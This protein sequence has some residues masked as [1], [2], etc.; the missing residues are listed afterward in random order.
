MM[1][2]LISCFVFAIFLTVTF[3][4]TEAWAYSYGDNITIS[5]DNKRS[6]FAWYSDK[7]DQE[8]EPGMR[9]GQSW[10]LEGFFLDG[11]SLS[12]IGGYDFR[13]GYGGFDSG[14]IFIDVNG[15]AEYG[16]IH[17]SSTND[18]SVTD[19][20]GYD[21]VFDLDFST[22]TYNLYELGSGTTTTQTTFYYQNQ[23]SNPWRYE[24]GGTLL[25]EG[26]FGFSE[27]LSDKDV[28]GLAGGDHYAV[29]D[30]DLA[31][32]AGSDFIAHFTMDCGNDNLMG[33]GTVPTPEPASMILLGTGLLG[34]VGL[35]RKVHR[36]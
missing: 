26:S 34:A 8:V 36:R 19:T 33:K 4:C 3:S 16:D 6:N 10:D 22:S 30:I 2:R 9:T 17:N 7:E 21:Y 28:G 23:G 15:D 1:K 31:F 18:R 27:G 29:T 11:V 35:R 14:D 25:G 24:S 12:M 5:D 32:L 13:D 20:F